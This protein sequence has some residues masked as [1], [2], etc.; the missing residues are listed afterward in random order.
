MVTGTKHT[1]RTMEQTED[2]EIN[3]HSY[4]HVILGSGAKNIYLRKKKADFVTS[5]AGKTIYPYMAE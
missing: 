3:P 4:R 2:P 5:S 1:C